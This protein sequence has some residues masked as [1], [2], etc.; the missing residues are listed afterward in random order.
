[1]A[2]IDVMNSPL[3]NPHASPEFYEDVTTKRLFAWCVDVVI[4]AALALALSAFTFFT[5]LLIFPLFY[6]FISFVYRWITLTGGSATLGMRLFSVE[7]R[8]HE[9]ALFDARMA[10]LHTAGYFVSVAVFPLQLI[11]I[12]MM[13]WTE[14]RQGLSDMMLGTVA[15]NKR[16]L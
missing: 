4:I 2:A 1:M 7:F 15:I 14:R 8:D 10:F 3:P 9:G 6:A 12:G 13:L 11:S 16:A 5:V